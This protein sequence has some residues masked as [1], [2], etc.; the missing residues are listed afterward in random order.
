MLMQDLQVYLGNQRLLEI[1][2]AMASGAEL[3]L[4]DEPAAGMNST[5]K[6]S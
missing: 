2:R 6:E 3:L 4:L 1:I 5:E